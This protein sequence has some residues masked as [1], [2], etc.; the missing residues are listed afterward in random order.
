MVGTQKISQMHSYDWNN[1]TGYL[2]AKRSAL[3]TSC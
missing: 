1:E 2:D 3:E